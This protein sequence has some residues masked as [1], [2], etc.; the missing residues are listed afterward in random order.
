MDS[1]LNQNNEELDFFFWPSVLANFCQLENYRLNLKD[2]KNTDLLKYL[3]HQDNDYLKEII[4]QNELI[5]QQ[6][7]EILKNIKK[8]K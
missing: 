6:N 4:I 3:E 8:G 5:I 2:L 7:K 1:F